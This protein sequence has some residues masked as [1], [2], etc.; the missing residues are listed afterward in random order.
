MTEP[1]ISLAMFKNH[2][3]IYNALPVYTVHKQPENLREN[4]LFIFLA[5]VKDILS[6]RIYRNLSLKTIRNN[7]AYS[8][9]K[10]QSCF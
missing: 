3:S 7:A 6:K 4:I 10:L 8:L 1:A 2:F 5:I 9:R